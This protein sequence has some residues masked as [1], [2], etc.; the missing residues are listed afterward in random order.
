MMGSKDRDFSPL[1]NV[2]LE[3]LVPADHFYRHLHKSLDLSFVRDL[4]A[5][6]Y[7]AGGR[8]S[9]DPVVFFKLQLVMFFE[10][11]RSERQLVRTAADRLSVRWYLGYDLHEHL[12]D[13]S[14]L[15]RIRDRYGVDTFRRF[16]EHIVEQCQQAGLVWGKELYFDGTQVQANADDDAML[17]RFYVEAMQSMQAK[18]AIQT[19]LSALFPEHPDDQCHQAPARGNSDPDDPGTPGTGAGPGLLRL[20]DKLPQATEPPQAT[21]EVGAEGEREQ[22]SA[23]E[24]Q[25]QEHSQGHGGDWI[26]RLGRPANRQPNSSYRRI[27][28][29]VVSTTDPDA[30]FMFDKNGGAAH[31]GYHTHYAVDG[32]KARI[33]LQALVTP[34]E[35]QDNQPMLDLLWRAC[36]RW[37]LPAQAGYWGHQV[38]HTRD[39]QG[40]R[41]G[42]HACLHPSAQ[43]R[44]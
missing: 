29:L 32:G 28:D 39:P 38:R 7:A 26:T 43:F 4:V 6:F 17:P 18:Q 19:H 34:S 23:T 20:T 41:G 14:T 13:H 2:S 36:F 12:P 22:V 11:I 40:Y 33:I 8:P 25:R 31:L 37:R 35:V 3:H 44:G 24:P 42:R 30:T 15:T 1:V 9:V 10:G 27:A 5:P 21:L 16:F